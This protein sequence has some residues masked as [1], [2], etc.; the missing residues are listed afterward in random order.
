MIDSTLD[1]TP[2]LNHSSPPTDGAGQANTCH[3]LSLRFEG[4]LPALKIPAF[5]LGG[6]G[7][8]H[9]SSLYFLISRH[10]R[11]G[12]RLEPSF[13]FPPVPHSSIPPSLSVRI[14]SA[15]CSGIWALTKPRTVPGHGHCQTRQPRAPGSAVRSSRGGSGFSSSGGWPALGPREERACDSQGLPIS[16][17]SIT[18][19]RF[20]DKSPECEMWRI[21][22][23]ICVPTKN[24][25]WGSEA[26]STNSARGRQRPSG[27]H[28]DPLWAQELAFS[29]SSPRD[30]AHS[31]SGNPLMQVARHSWSGAVRFSSGEKPQMN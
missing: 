16:G 9:S 10:Q 31:Q 2:S 26:T 15:S 27:G 4:P 5:P 19:F 6:A 8:P 17:L 23:T 30:G 3:T 24:G 7:Q 21:R 22:K 12:Q 29:E 13:S 14:R 20:G 1:N 25:L 28:R 18:P 11:R